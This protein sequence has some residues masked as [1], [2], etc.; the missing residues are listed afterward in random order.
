MSQ[1]LVA[2]QDETLIA[3][4]AAE[5]P[6]SLVIVAEQGLDGE[7]V[8]E[9]L[10]HS[11][12]S[13]VRLVVPE[14]DKKFISVQQVRDVMTSVRTYALERRVIIFRPAG[15][16]TEEAQNA[17]LKALEEPSKKLH[18]ILETEELSQMLPTILSRCQTLTLHR[19][20]SLQDNTLL[21]QS[22]VDEQSR[23]QIRFLAAGRPALIRRLTKQ[24]DLLKQYQELASDAKQLLQSSRYDSLVIAQ[25]YA[26][27][28]EQALTLI[29]IVLTMIRFRLISHGTDTS[30][31]L[32]LEKLTTTEEALRTNANVKLAL[33]GLVV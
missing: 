2:R 7:R 12:P 5:L 19:T 3:Q 1:A 14:K 27:N 25:K 17:L 24:P 10:S 16:M 21:K 32:L 30:A 31:E 13:D 29:D 15:T 4:F 9:S 8:S 26:T 28:R 18:F 23:Q 6:Q 22:S 20:S 33:L 11:Q